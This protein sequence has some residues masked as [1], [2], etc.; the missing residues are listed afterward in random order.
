MSRISSLED[1]LTSFMRQHNEQ[2]KNLTN[3]VGL[4]GQSGFGSKK[5]QVMKVA[6][7]TENTDSPNKRKRMEESNGSNSGSDKDVHPAGIVSEERSTFQSFPPL[8][9]SN[10][11][12]HPPGRVSNTS[13]RP[14]GTGESVATFH[15][16]WGISYSRVATLQPSGITGIDPIRSEASSQQPK[17][18]PSILFGT[19]RTGKDNGERLLAADVCLVA[20]GVSKVA[21]PNQLMEFVQSKGISVTNVELLTQH[22]E[23]RTNT[24]KVVIKPAD[25]EKAMNPEVW[26]YRVGV[27]HYKAP[28][29]KEGMSW[30]EQSKQ[31][32]GGQHSQGGSGNGGNQANNLSHN[33]QNR[34]Q[35]NQNQNRP[36]SFN[37][38][39]QNR[40]QAL[41]D[42]NGEVFIHN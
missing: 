38:D 34:Q 20:S 14:S 24:F 9:S 7:S 29:R 22:P 36:S 30:N 40:Y 33:Q 32:G 1:S 42:Q 31:A 19:A 25:Y 21:T 15:P 37:L 26:P 23:A 12:F 18:K 39:L 17:R 10:A 8:G 2:I 27:R 4:L 3:T 35:R 11:G 6:K 13:G 5:T 28:R 41:A 16:P